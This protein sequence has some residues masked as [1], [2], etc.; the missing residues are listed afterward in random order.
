MQTP[1]VCVV[2]DKTGALL[3]PQYQIAEDSHTAMMIVDTAESSKMLMTLKQIL[4]DIMT[5]QRIRQV[6]VENGR[7]GPG[8]NRHKMNLMAAAHADYN[9]HGGGQTKN[10]NN[11]QKE[12]EEKSGFFSSWFG[13]GNKN[14]NKKDNVDQQQQQQQTQS[15][16]QLL[17]RDNLHHNETR[18]S[19]LG[20]QDDD[21]APD[22]QNNNNNNAD[23]LFL[24]SAGALSSGGGG[25]DEGIVPNVNNNNNDF[26]FLDGAGGAGGGGK[27]N[28]SVGSLGDG[29]QSES[30]VS[31]SGMTVASL[32]F[33]QNALLSRNCCDSS[34]FRSASFWAT[35][36]R[37]F[38][39][40]PNK[41]DLSFVGLGSDRD[42]PY[43]MEKKKIAV[44]ESQL[45]M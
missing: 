13:S 31:L 8:R 2:D 12:K 28:L 23:N 3:I 19:K 17:T 25:A 16:F 4:T 10:N 24:F 32:H 1:I 15:Q 33:K 9:N 45:R 5:E 11:Q 29:Q 34:L 43:W 6:I 14:K 42:A 21:D 44:F 27:P 30:G 40:L 38:S 37:R 35:W 39:H 41:W 18:L 22:H 36:C 20:Q 26:T 7:N